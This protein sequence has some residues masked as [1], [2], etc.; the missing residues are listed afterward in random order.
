MN[1]LPFQITAFVLL[2]GVLA[3]LSRNALRDKATHGFTRF[4]AW[5]AILALL[6]WNAP[7]WQ[8]DMFS[9]RQIASWVLLFTSPVLAVLG[10]QALK[11]EGQTSALRQDD[12]L[13]AFEK[14]GQLVTT[15]IFALI[16]HPMYSALLLLAW[17]IYLK[18]MNL[19]TTALVLLASWALW[20]TARRDEAECLAYFGDAYA[21]YMKTTRRFIP[22]LL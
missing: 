9:P 6:V 14:T 11:R 13:F 20:L 16:R 18:G 3:F 7:V 15:R 2:S 12:A 1:W 22:Y 10:L 5:E 8:D 4:F 21:R 17:G 19:G